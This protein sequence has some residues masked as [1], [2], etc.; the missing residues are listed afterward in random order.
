MA[1]ERREVSPGGTV[2]LTLTADGLDAYG[3]VTD[4]G[5][6]TLFSTFL[7]A[8]ET[9]TEVRARGTARVSYLADGLQDKGRRRL[10][11]RDYRSWLPH[12]SR[13][14]ADERQLMWRL[15][16]SSSVWFGSVAGS[17]IGTYTYEPRCPVRRARPGS[18]V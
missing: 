10:V 17:L 13:E 12:L 15:P 8:P 18:R 14:G 6:L 16:T 2:T 11:D 4:L 3:F 5:D 1:D 9:H 7:A